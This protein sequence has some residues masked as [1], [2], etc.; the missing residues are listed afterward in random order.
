MWK[1]YWLWI[2]VG[3]GL[4][5]WPAA[6]LPPVLLNH[7]G[8]LKDQ[9]NSPGGSLPAQPA[10]SGIAIFVQHWQNKH[11]FPSQKSPNRNSLFAQSNFLILCPK[12]PWETDTWPQC[13][14]NF[15]PSGNLLPQEQLLGTWCRAQVTGH[16]W[17]LSS[18]TINPHNQITRLTHV[19][20][21]SVSPWRKGVLGKCLSGGL[22]SN[23]IHLSSTDAAICCILQWEA[24]QRPPQRK[25]TFVSLPQDWQR[26]DLNWGEILTAARSRS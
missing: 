1:L 23:S 12:C 11:I 26:W 14:G 9:Q 21:D 3:L 20:H 8:L 2:N 25:E 15:L 19:P 22:G 24:S 6:G 7:C 4:W 17:I 5:T 13:F 10:L 18:F 16:R